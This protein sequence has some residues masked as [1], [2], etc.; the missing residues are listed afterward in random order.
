MLELYDL[1]TKHMKSPVID[2]KPYFSWKLKS[3]KQ[4]VM[5]KTY[6]I[7]VKNQE[8]IVWNSGKREE[9]EQSFVEYQGETLCSR[10]DY[11]WTVTVWDN[12]GEEAT[13]R[14]TFTTALLQKTDWQAKWIECS[15]TREP[16]N[17]YKFGNSYPGILFEKQIIVSKKV[18]TAKAY[19]QATE[20]IG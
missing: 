16:K 5:Q 6:Q 2:Q 3:D 10:S 4:N 11:E 9:K 1:K 15:F 20:L 12:Q 7:V 19:A 14:A 8:K 13:A 18:K 17:E